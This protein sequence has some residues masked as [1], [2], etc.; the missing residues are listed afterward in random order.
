MCKNCYHL[1]G[2]SKP[3]YR[4]PHPTQPNYARGLCKNCYLT[5]YHK[6][7]KKKNNNLAVIHQD[8]PDSSMSDPVK[9]QNEEAIP[10]NMEA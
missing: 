1:K 8:K 6:V 2:R 4:C 3:A 5:E 10:C 7:Y 9:K